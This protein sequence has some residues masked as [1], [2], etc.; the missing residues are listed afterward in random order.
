[1]SE[2]EFSKRLSIADTK[3]R[4]RKLN[5]EEKKIDLDSAIKLSQPKTN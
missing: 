2:A 1:M 5:I 3:L 4:E